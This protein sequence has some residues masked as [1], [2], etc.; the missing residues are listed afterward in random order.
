MFIL[1]AISTNTISHARINESVGVLK[2]ISVLWVH[3]GLKLDFKVFREV[4]V[5]ELGSS[6]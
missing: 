4:R 2:R 6:Y 3:R 1:S 5:I